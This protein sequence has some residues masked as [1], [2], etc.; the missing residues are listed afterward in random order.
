LRSAA[1]IP[2]GIINFFWEFAWKV[3][4]TP[5]AQTEVWR[6]TGIN[7]MQFW[8]LNFWTLLEN[9][10]MLLHRA[11]E[12]WELFRVLFNQAG[13]EVQLGSYEA[14]V[15]VC[16]AWAATV[17]PRVVSKPMAQVLKKDPFAALIAATVVENLVTALGTNVL[18]V[19]KRGLLTKTQCEALVCYKA[20]ELHCCFGS[21]LVSRVHEGM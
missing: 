19:M 17:S 7:S 6:A 2:E 16:G 10:S 8:N 4:T 3:V 15:T 14:L 9:R 18:V 21:F 5:A 11:N 20:S 1:E 13:A 12:N